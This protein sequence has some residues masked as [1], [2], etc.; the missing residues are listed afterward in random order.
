MKLRAYSILSFFAV[1]LLII[2]CKKPDNPVI[3]K[4]PPNAILASEANVVI[5]PTSLTL[6]NN[7]VLLYQ[8]TVEFESDPSQQNLAN[9]R[10]LWLNATGAYEQSCAMLFGPFASLGADPASLINTYPIDTAGIDA[11]IHSPAIF[12]Q[13]YIDSLPSYLIGFHGFEYVL[14]GADGNKEA[15]QFTSQQLSYIKQVALSIELQTAQLDSDWN[16]SYPGNYNYQFAYAGSGSTTYPDQ[17]AAFSDLIMAIANICETDA[18]YKLNGS[19]ANKNILLQ[20]SPFANNSLEDIQNNIIGVRN[21]YLGQY[22]SQTGEGLS[23]FVSQYDAPFDLKIKNDLNNVIVALNKIT[24]PLNQAI[25]S[26]P[27]QIHNAMNMCDS[28]D[29]D[30]KNDLQLFVDKYAK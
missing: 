21:I 17:R 22:N 30:L 18:I 4:T 25:M 29:D 11:I 3:P 2:G 14:Y 9:C 15:S 20:E 28:L 12:T 6:A 27:A 26:Q 10:Q 23:Q 19:L 1:T 16:S 13:N 8:A 24:V 7:A 5:E